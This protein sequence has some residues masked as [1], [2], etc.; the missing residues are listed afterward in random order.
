MTETCNV[1]RVEYD[2]DHSIEHPG[3]CCDCFDKEFSDEAVSV[4]D[5]AELYKAAWGVEPGAETKP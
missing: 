2:C 3:L 5:Q 1:C 4:A